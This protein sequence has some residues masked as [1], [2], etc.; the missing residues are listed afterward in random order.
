M[1]EQLVSLGGRSRVALVRRGRHLEYFTIIYNSLEGLVA[2]VAGLIAGSIALVGFGFD[3]L[4]EVTSGAVLLWRLYSDANEAQRERVEAVSLRIV[5]V[6]FVLLAGY[7]TF[8][9]VKSL[10]RHEAPNES[11]PGIVLAALSLIVMPLLVRA[12]RKVARGINSGALMADS[13]Q[14][15]LCTY[16]SAILLGGLLLNALLGWWWADPVA[17]LIMVPIIA[18]EGLEALRG[19]TCCDDPACH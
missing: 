9:S 3:S 13:K 19:E 15:E 11:V 12:K 10:W 16:L 14:T 6:L 8:D 17:A 5:G 2:L 7:V 18:K 1:S 4:I